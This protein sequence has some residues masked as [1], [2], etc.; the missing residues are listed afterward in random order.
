[1]KWTNLAVFSLLTLLLLVSLAI[2][3][4][5]EQS[6]RKHSQLPSK[7]TI[8]SGRSVRFHLVGDYGALTNTSDGLLG[9]S[10]IPVEIVAQQ[11]ANRTG[12]FPIDFITT[13]GDNVYPSGMID[14]FDR[15]QFTLMYETFNKPGLWGKPWYPT[16]GNHDCENIPPMLEITHF[17]PMWNLPS[18]YYN[19]TLT[20]DNSA[21]AVLVFLN[22]CTIAC[23]Q[24]L[25]YCDYNYTEAEILEQYAWLE[26]VLDGAGAATWIMVFTHIPPFS[27]GSGSGDDEALKLNLYPILVRY[28]VTFLFGGHEHLAEYLYSPPNSLYVPADPIFTNYTYAK[29]HCF[30]YSPYL[31]PFVSSPLIMSKSDGGLHNVIIGSSGHSLD[32]LCVNRTTDMAQLLFG[33]TDWGWAEVGMTSEAVTVNFMSIVEQ[34]P[35]FTLI[36]EA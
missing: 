28:N 22:G 27:A 7:P 4:P 5:V 23:Q 24:K 10:L 35:Q 31:A 17:Y 26:G 15:T 21:T 20:L 19:L 18:P 8:P 30:P 6:S 2:T 33:S 1:M 16:L 13:T 9:Q 29:A 3:I 12:S 14:I 36:V 11:M 32:T 25:I 34:E